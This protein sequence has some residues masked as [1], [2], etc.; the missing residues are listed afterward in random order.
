MWLMLLRMFYSEKWRHLHGMPPLIPVSLLLLR[1]MMINIS[2]LGNNSTRIIVSHRYRRSYT[3]DSVL[4]MESLDT[5][6]EECCGWSGSEGRWSSGRSEID[7]LYRI[8]EVVLGPWLTLLSTA[9]AT[10][11]SYFL[12]SK[13]GIWDSSGRGGTPLWLNR[14]GSRIA[15]DIICWISRLSFRWLTPGHSWS[16][17]G[18]SARER[19]SLPFWYI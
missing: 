4:S 8:K 7:F 3:T 2:T 19:E 15:S 6:E 9:V 11:C 16:H 17:T 13:K 18:R 10:S 1:P 14:S 12:G 5:E